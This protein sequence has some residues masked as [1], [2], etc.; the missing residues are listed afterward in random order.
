M[1]Q[2]CDYACMASCART[3]LQIAH[4]RLLPASQGPLDPRPSTPA[5]P[6]LPSSGE[7]P[8]PKAAKARNVSFSLS[9]LSTP[10]VQACGQGKSVN[11]FTDVLR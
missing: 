11:Q 9:R 8:E 3:L 1:V 7:L 5:Q 4:P 6:T 2:A 10:G